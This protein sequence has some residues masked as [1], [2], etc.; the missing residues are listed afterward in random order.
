[1][2]GFR[3]S[4]KVGPFRFTLSKRGISTSA[5]AGPLRVGR[6]ADGKYRRTWRL[7]GTGL[8]D[9]KVIGGGQQQPHS[10]PAAAASSA[11]GAGWYPDPAGGGS[12]YWDG[13]MWHDAVP[14]AA[15]RPTGGKPPRKPISTRALLI[16]AAAFIAVVVIG[17]ILETRHEDSKAASRATTGRTTA[18]S[19]VAAAPV[20]PERTRIEDIL[21]PDEIAEARYSAELI[22]D[23]VEF[24][25]DAERDEL[26]LR[27]RAVCVFLSQPGTSLLSAGVE[28][29]DTYGYSRQ[30]AG[31]IV[32]AAVGVFC[33]ERAP[34]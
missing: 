14:A 28:L 31:S 29:M 11:P 33:P 21:S 19:S 30:D 1:M 26:I 17:N 15:G 2:V 10:H 32:V 22:A 12:R 18:A 13:V 24:D 20:A 4:K 8:Y 27:G 5:G 6:G 9:T 25:G 34:R 7:P 16:A 23:G 3:K